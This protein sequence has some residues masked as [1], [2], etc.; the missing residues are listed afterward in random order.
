V[1]VLPWSL[2]Y[3]PAVTPIRVA[4]LV[5]DG[6]EVL[7]FCGPFEVFSAVRG[8]G[9]QR[10]TAPLFRVFTVAEEDRIITATGGLEVKPSDTLDACPPVEILIVPGGQGTR[11]EVG[12]APLMSWLAGRAP[13]TPVMASVCTGAFLL[14]QTGLLDGKR[15]T[16]HWASMDRLRQTYP[17]V[18]VAADERVVDE[19]RVVTAAGVS[20]GID[21][22]LLLVERYAGSNVAAET[23]RWME[24]TRPPR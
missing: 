4:I 13:A 2:G 3:T 17:H 18:R 9:A 7:D 11:R 23:A 12:N 20:A 19:G 22:S 1:R 8:G 5:F 16:T 24:Y 6:V 21:M 10:D 14:A 15:A